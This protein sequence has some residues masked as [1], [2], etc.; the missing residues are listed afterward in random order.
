MAQRRIVIVGASRSGVVTAEQLRRAGWS[1]AIILV[2]AE[3]RPP[4]D[5]PP[6]S[7][8]FLTGASDGS[9]LGLAHLLPD[10][11]EL[12]L[13]VE[14]IEL[15]IPERFIALANGERLDF[16]GIVI[17]SGVRARR[18]AGPLAAL[19]VLRTID[20]ALALR[21]SIGAA[22]RVAVVGGGFIGA[23][24]CSIARSLGKSAILLEADSQPLIRAV[25]PKMGGLVADLHR[26]N[27]V[28]IHCDAVV[29]GVG[30]GQN[31]PY[32][33]HLD[34]GLVVEADAVLQ[35]VGTVPNIDWLQGSG[36]A[37]GNGVICD[38]G[39]RA[40]DGI[41]AVGDVAC[42]N[43]PRYGYVRVEHWANANDHAV[44]AAGNLVAELNG[45]G[46]CKACDVVP[47][48][49]SDQHGLKIQL[50]GIP[51]GAEQVEVRSDGTLL[52]ALFGQAGTLAAAMTW[53][54]PRELARMRHQ[55]AAG[56]SLADVRPALDT[57]PS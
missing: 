26:R 10:D 8:E 7:K 2:G 57:V 35:A 31:S 27:G 22:E 4:Y 40:S 39:L 42:W 54:M 3:S 15:S 46:S 30:E 37:L 12:Q 28:E 20:D 25:G 41:Y 6:L 29:T 52:M 45:S 44:V 19:P 34:S 56:P 23:E 17:A 16:D 21:E 43:H 9:D 51:T 13:G 18:L 47:Y 14:A 38:A 49:W 36:L 1:E 11:V 50:A 5:R 53:N 33:L 48:F 24:V 32:L 55:L